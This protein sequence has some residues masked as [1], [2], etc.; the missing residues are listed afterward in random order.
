MTHST[1]PLHVPPEWHRQRVAESVAEFCAGNRAEAMTLAMMAGVD[2]AALGLPVVAVPHEI[3]ARPDLL[4]EYRW[5]FKIAEAR[6]IKQE[7]GVLI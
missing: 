7:Q 2:A 4:S 5:G 6:K 1:R 3:A